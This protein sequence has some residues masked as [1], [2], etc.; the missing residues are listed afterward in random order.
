MYLIIISSL[1][2]LILFDL[3]QVTV[4]SGFFD[5]GALA[6]ILLSSLVY[7]LA[8]GGRE[9]FVQGFSIFF[10]PQQ[11][12]KD[13]VKKR[14]IALFTHCGKFV[15]EV[16]AILSLLRFAA[17][18]ELGNLYVLLPLVYALLISRLLLVPVA[19]RVSYP[20]VS[21]ELSTNFIVPKPRKEKVQAIPV[22]TESSKERFISELQE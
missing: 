1:I 21:K 19:G 16:G 4:L 12:V 11:N 5:A 18:G 10:N 7:V 20:S 14:V 3:R 2:A 13:H 17:I 15:V 9:D 8:L 22:E 6:I